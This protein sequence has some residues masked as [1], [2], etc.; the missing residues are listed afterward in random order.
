MDC[1]VLVREGNTIYLWPNDGTIYGTSTTTVTVGMDVIAWAPVYTASQTFTATVTGNGPITAA[2][3]TMTQRGIFDDYPLFKGPA[4]NTIWVHY[5]TT[6]GA[7]IADTAPEAQG[8]YWIAATLGPEAL[9]TT[10]WSGVGFTPSGAL[11]TSAF[12]TTAVLDSD[13]FTV[14]CNDWMFYGILRNLHYFLKD[15]KRT[16][17]VHRLYGEALTATLAWNEGISDSETSDYTLD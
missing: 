16:Q 11:V 13:M 12:L 8:S 2:A 7:W 1:P 5:N 14:E 17:E 3:Y 10:L 9:S 15:E 4:N 6:L